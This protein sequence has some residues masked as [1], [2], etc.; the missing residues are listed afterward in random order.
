MIFAHTD[1]YKYYIHIFKNNHKINHNKCLNLMLSELQK[2]SKKKLIIPTYNYDFGHK[3]I[4][5]KEKD[6]SQYVVV[7]V[8]IA[9]DDDRRGWILKCDTGDEFT[10]WM[11]ALRG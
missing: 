5:C 3:N 2:I 1:Y 6:K 9:E 4:F 7:L 11:T 10:R 8:P